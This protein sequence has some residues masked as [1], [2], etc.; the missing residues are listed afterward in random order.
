MKNIL[1]YLERTQKR[2]PCKTAVDDGNIRMT[3]VELTRLAQGMGTAFARRTDPGRPVVILMEK[4]AAVLA[5]M[6]GVVYAGCFYVMLDPGQ[7]VQRRKKILETLKPQL[8]VGDE[9]T[10]RKVRETGL[11]IPVCFLEDAVKTKPDPILLGRIRKEAKE[12]DLLYSLFTSGSTGTPKGVAVS[13]QAVIQFLGHFTEIFD[14]RADDRI[15]NQAPFDFDVSV[16]DIYSCVMTGATLVLIPK[17]YFSIPPRLVDLLCEKRITVMIWAV[18]ALCLI[19]ALKGLEYRIPKDVR[20]VMFSGEVMPAGQLICWQEAL[21]E[22]EFI[23]LYG[24][25]EVTCNCTFYRI[26]EKWE[27]FNRLPI[28][29][30][31]PGRQVF[32]LDEKGERITEEG[33]AGEICVSGESLAEGYYNNPEETK[34]RFHFYTAQS[35]EEKC[36][37]HTGDLGF[38]GENG[39]LYF[40]GRKDF[41]IKYMGHRIELEEIEGCLEQ[42]EGVSRCCCIFDREK[43]RIAAFYTGKEVPPVV[44]KELKDKVP[45]YMVPGKITRVPVIPLNKNGKTDR[46]YFQNRQEV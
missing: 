42:M 28:G 33:K 21:P 32:L 10:A 7:P 6:L 12:T 3:W 40:A 31:F 13:H 9:E 22:A 46:A 23:N 26:R 35:G 44:R 41:Q 19:S 17:E 25:T 29:S 38:Y 5:A 16:K 18:S 1:D 15:G 30:A 20:I 4:S 11:E 34:K 37:Y 24:P 14:L 36:C 45:S 8:I 2:Y 43:R 27:A 39:L